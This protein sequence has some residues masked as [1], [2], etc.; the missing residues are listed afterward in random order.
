M[1][2][3]VDALESEEPPASEPVLDPPVLPHAARERIAAL[4]RVPLMNALLDMLLFIVLLLPVV[5]CAQ[6]SPPPFGPP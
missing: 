6:T 2:P 3:P 4:V 1:E 5:H